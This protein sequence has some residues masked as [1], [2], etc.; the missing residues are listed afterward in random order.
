MPRSNDTLRVTLGPQDVFNVIEFDSSYRTLFP[1]SVAASDQALRQASQFV[2]GLEASGGTEIAA[3]LRA[4][5]ESP[6]Q[7]GM[8]K[9]I[10]FMTDGAVGNESAL[11][12]MIDDKLGDA[13]LF[14]VGIGSAPNSFFMRKAAEFGRGTFTCIGDTSEVGER[15]DRLLQKLERPVA[16]NL[17]I[18]WRGS[19][20]PDVC[21]R[22]LPTLYDGEPLLVTAQS[23]YLTGDALVRA[24]LN[25]RSWQ[26][27]VRLTNSAEESGIG[28]L[29]ARAKIESLEY[30]LVRSASDEGEIRSAIVEVALNHQLMSR[31]TSLVAVESFRLTPTRRSVR[32]EQCAE[33]DAAGTNDGVDS[34]DSHAC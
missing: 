33:S 2:S 26:Q 10:V 15:I 14:T 29:W 13:R 23:E 7:E 9:H 5:L 3:P 32:A 21:P 17:E 30:K 11:F 22:R 1:E 12:G 27:R 19:A 24:E 16:R 20:P 31:F 6:T 34:R 4:A 8:L 18:D 25:G 28:T